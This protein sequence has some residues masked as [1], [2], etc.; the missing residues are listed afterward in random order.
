[1]KNTTLCGNR[2]AMFLMIMTLISLSLALL[3]IIEKDPE[4]QDATYGFMMFTFFFGIPGVWLCIRGRRK[5][6]YQ[7]LS[8]QLSG[9]FRSHDSFTVAEMSQKIGKTEMETECLI[10]D[11]IETKKINLVFHRST[12]QY[13]HKNRIHKKY[14]Q[15][16]RCSACGAS[17]KQEIIFE[18]EQ[19][20]CQ[21]CGHQM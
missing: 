16:D 7:R 20:A 18:G 4:N 9:Y 10:F 5:E 14:H 13:L 11:L 12:R 3:T 2:F 15:I 1:M 17:L 21:Y 19:I 6:H 8:Q